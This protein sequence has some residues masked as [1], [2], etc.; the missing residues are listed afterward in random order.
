[1]SDT[2]DR[3]KVAWIRWW[4]SRTPKERALHRERQG[5]ALELATYEVPLDVDGIPIG[6]TRTVESGAFAVPTFLLELGD[7]DPLDA[8]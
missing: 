3:V 1:M 4:S 8:A 5:Q 6:V 2:K 7:D